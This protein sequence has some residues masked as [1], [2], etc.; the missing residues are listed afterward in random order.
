MPKIQETKYI[1]NNKNY[2]KFYISVPSFLIKLK[3]L[4]KGDHLNFLEDKEGIFLNFNCS[5]KDD[6][7]KHIPKIQETNKD[8]SPKYYITIPKFV[9]ELK[10]LKKGNEINF[11]DKNGKIYLDFN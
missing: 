4:K 6:R 10:N 7:Q 8:S 11:I 1:K 5:F 2:N 3:Q 9:V